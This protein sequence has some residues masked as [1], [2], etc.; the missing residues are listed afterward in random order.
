MAAAE[1]RRADQLIFDQIAT[2]RTFNGDSEANYD[3]QKNFRRLTREFDNGLK[4][5]V[6]R[7]MWMSS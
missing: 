3:W 1:L 4:Y 2:L 6:F 7:L 5:R